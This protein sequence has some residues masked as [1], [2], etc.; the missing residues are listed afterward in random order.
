MKQVMMRCGSAV[1]EEVPAPGVEPGTDLV[2]VAHW[3]ISGAEVSGLRSTGRSLMQ[4]ARE[5]L[6]RLR[7]FA[8]AF[9][10][11][12]R[13]RGAWPIPLW[14][15]VQAAGIAPAVASQLASR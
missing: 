7:A 5:Q 13:E 9:A 10:R 15:Q 2:R 14:Q 6:A 4:C 8:R 3:C 11:A 12:V 1:V